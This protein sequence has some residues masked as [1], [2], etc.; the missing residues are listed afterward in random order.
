MG[1]GERRPVMDPAVP[2]LRLLR[3]LDRAGI[4]Y[5]FVGSVASGI[6]GIFRT[7]AD[8][9]LVADI[10]PSQAATF[11]RELGS[12]FYADVDMISDALRAG[13]SFNVIHIPSTTKFDVFPLRSD[14]YH[15]S[16]FGRRRIEKVDLGGA[17]KVPVPVA[18]AEDTLLMKL[19]WYRSGGE[20]SERQWNDVRGIIAVQG[21]R[22]D[23]AYLSRWAAYLK[24]TDLLE[25]A[26]R[27]A[28]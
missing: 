28:G 13:R 26:L 6:H 3:A 9:D 4:A 22:L 2:L 10:Q 15:Q 24:V 14:P 25:E 23:R 7:T 8:L 12:E 16:E 17:E 5:L 11:A 20:V 18:T 19:V 27:Q 1:P 21:D